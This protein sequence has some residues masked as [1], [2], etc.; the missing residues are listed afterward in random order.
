MSQHLL[1]GSYEDLFF[2][3]Q[4][5]AEVGE[6]EQA[7]DLF[8][9]LLERLG[10]LSESVL[11]RRPGLRNV[12]LRA[13]LELAGLLESEGRYS[14]AIEVEEKLLQT[15]PDRS[16]LWRRE[17][18]FLRTAK[19]EV[20]QGIGELRALAEEDPDD[21]WSWI[22]LANEA[23]I[24]GRFAESQTAFAQALAAASRTVNAKADPK[25]LAEIHFGRFRLFEAM[26]ELDQAVAA[27]EEALALEPSVKHTVHDVY[28]MLTGAGCYA[29]ALE[30]VA[31]DDN[32]LQAGL[33]RGLIAEL[34]GHPEEATHEWQAVAALDPME[35]EQGHACWVEA[36]L[37]LKDPMPALEQLQQLLRHH[38]SVRLLVLAGIAWAM[39]GDKGPAQGLFEQSIRLLRRSRPAKQKL[40]SADWRLL[41]A[42]VADEEIRAALRPYFAVVERIFE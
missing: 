15:H 10:R 4:G 28:Q 18:A 24:E 1:P 5:L 34:T 17:L 32:T 35:F 42:L 8:T 7:L 20:D 12:Q 30:Y 29:Q 19:G 22:V 14:E 27:W 21:L 40:D 36:V 31:R 9:R 16:L 23:R 39:H 26:G 38:G 25:V 6:A 11:A 37:R 33:Q 2:R 41:T 3:A 13:C